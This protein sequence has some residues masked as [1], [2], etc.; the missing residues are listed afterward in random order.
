[1]DDDLGV[2]PIVGDTHIVLDNFL[3]HIMCMKQISIDSPQMEFF[4][5]G[6]MGVPT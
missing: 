4:Q 5:L 6:V 1:M 2:P 3:D